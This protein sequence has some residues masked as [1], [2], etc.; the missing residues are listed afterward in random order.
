MNNLIVEVCKFKA[1]QRPLLLTGVSYPEQES[2]E[3]KTISQPQCDLSIHLSIQK[4]LFIYPTQN[5]PSIIC[6]FFDPIK[7]R[8]EYH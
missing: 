4:L 1:N 3:S 6:H 5:R 8:V 2:G 7:I